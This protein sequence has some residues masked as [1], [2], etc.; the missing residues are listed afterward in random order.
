MNVNNRVDTE[1]THKPCYSDMHRKHRLPLL[2]HR[3]PRRSRLG[4]LL[5]G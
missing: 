3:Q 1:N 4:D 5:C 2:P